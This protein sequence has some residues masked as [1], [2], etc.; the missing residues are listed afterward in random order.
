MCQLRI[1]INY[2]TPA[3]PSWV[4]GFCYLLLFFNNLQNK[5]T[6]FSFFLLSLYVRQDRL[7][8]LLTLKEKLSKPMLCTKPFFLCSFGLFSLTVLLM[9]TTEILHSIGNRRIYSN[10]VL[11]NVSLNLKNMITRHLITRASELNHKLKIITYLAAALWR[12]RET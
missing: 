8:L 3:V 11:F 6:F 1:K 5:Y 10:F 12:R 2:G 7:L 9:T 4:S